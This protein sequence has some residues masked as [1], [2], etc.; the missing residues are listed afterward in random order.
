M[1]HPMLHLSFNLLA[2]SQLQSVLGTPMPKVAAG[3]P[4]L[5]DFSAA[6]TPTVTIGAGSTDDFVTIDDATKLFKIGGKVQRFV[7]M[8]PQQ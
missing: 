4:S 3:S 5:V 7:G 6:P 2:L 1:H 8:Y